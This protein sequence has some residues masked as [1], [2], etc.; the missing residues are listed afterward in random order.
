MPKQPFFNLSGV[1]QQEI[2]KAAM[3]EFIQYG[4]R[5]ASTNRI[6]QKIGISKGSLFYY[7]DGKE[8]L[9]TS[10]L[11]QAQSRFT[12]ILKQESAGWPREI[13]KRIELLTLQVIHLYGKYPLEQQILDTLTAADATDFQSEI[14]G[15]LGEESKSAF[16][17]LLTDVD[18]SGFRYSLE[19]TLPLILWTY[20]G[21]KL[22]INRTFRMHGDAG[23][24]EAQIVPRLRTALELLAEGIYKHGKYSGEKKRK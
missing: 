6:V 18:T 1:K 20:T 22:E 4:Y 14:L 7:F 21:I 15:R 2:E 19:D 13:C 17:E 3:E 9:Y 23:A 12:E 10:L 16:F 11:I 8:D 24:L 5:S